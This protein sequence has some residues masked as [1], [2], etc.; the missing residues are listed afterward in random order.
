MVDIP[1][2]T[3]GLSVLENNPY[4][5][6]KSGEVK[7]Q[8]Y[9]KRCHEYGYLNLLRTDTTGKNACHVAVRD[10]KSFGEWLK[11]KHHSYI[12]MRLR[13]ELGDKSKDDNLWEWFFLHT[14]QHSKRL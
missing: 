6:C 12:T 2:P 4:C 9:F 7:R 14:P 5:F 3:C 8:E 1:C 11:V 10:I 13:Y